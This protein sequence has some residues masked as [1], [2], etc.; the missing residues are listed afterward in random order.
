MDTVI[1]L[2]LHDIYSSLEGKPAVRPAYG[3]EFA[4]QRVIFEMSKLGVRVDRGTAEKNWAAAQ[5]RRDELAAGF[6]D[7]NLN[8]PKQLASLIYDDWGLPCHSWTDSGNRSTAKQTLE[9]MEALHPGIDAILEYRKIDKAISG[10]YR[11]LVERLDDNERVHT[12]FNSARTVLGRLSASNPNLQ[13]IPRGDVLSGVRDL[14]IPEP[15]WELWEYDLAQA[16]LRVIASLAGETD[17]IE[18]IEQGR[19]LH[20][21]TAAKV[22]GADFKP[23]QRRVAKNLNF[24]VPYF[25]GPR[26]L[27]NYYVI[28]T[29]KKKTQCATWSWVKESGEKRP[30]RCNRCHV[31]QAAVAIDGWKEA[32]SN[33]AMLM[34]GLDRMAA[35]LGYLPHHVKGRYRHFRGPRGVRVPTYTGLNAVV[36]GGVAELMKSIM[37]EVVEQT[38]EA[39]MVLQVHD[40]LVFEVQPDYG[41]TLQTILQTITDDLNPYTMRMVFD[42]QPW[43]SHV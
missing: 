2:K 23:I 15:G 4:F 21:E 26:K 27:S 43:S 39:R 41:L 3:R 20:S 1:T 32:N 34:K 25:V 7:V 24:S 38:L 14:F 17:M 28:G 30:R 6:G 42:A 40:S 12:S 19:D 18:A 8:S 11:P 36:Q 9:E 35:Q 31:C 5:V 29:G 16:E 22:F 37:L 13:T 10:Y 33:I